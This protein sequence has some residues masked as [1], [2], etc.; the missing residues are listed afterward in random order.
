[1][2]NELILPSFSIS[3]HLSTSL[4]LS[5]S[6]STP[7]LP[8]SLPSLPLTL[9][10]FHFLSIPS[11]LSLCSWCQ[12]TAESNMDPFPQ[13]ST[14]AHELRGQPC[15]KTMLTLPGTRGLL[16]PDEHQSDPLDM[17]FT[18]T[19][20]NVVP[21]V[22]SFCLHILKKVWCVYLKPFQCWRGWKMNNN[23]KTYGESK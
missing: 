17:A 6:V 12:R 9:L 20:T 3:P 10:P 22:R 16:N 14:H 21:Q 8:P 18:Y 15:W 23:Q 11:S 2:Q 7:S 19:M 4:Y 1:M 5:V 13:S